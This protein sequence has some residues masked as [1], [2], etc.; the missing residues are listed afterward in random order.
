MSNVKLMIN[1]IEVEVPQ[2]TTLIQAAK[3]AGYNVP[4]LC[5]HPDLKPT[6]ACGVCIVDIEGSPVPK[7][8]CSTV[9]WEGMKVTTNTKKLREARKTLIELILANHDVKCPTCVANGKCELQEIA[10]TLDI[11]PEAVPSMLKKVPVDHSSVSIIRDVNKCINCGRCVQVCSEI[12][13]VNA[14]TFSNR[15]FETK[16]DTALSLGMANSVCVNC[17]QC[18]V[19]CPTGALHEKDDTAK[20]W[21]A[22]LDPTKH[23][24]VQEAPSIR[25]SLGEEFGMEFGEVNIGKMYAALKRLGFDGVFDTNYTADLTIIEEGSEV[26]SRVVN[27]GPLPC[28]TSCSPGWV[29]F[30]ETFFPDLAHHVSTAKSPQQMMG[31]L[32]KT[33][34]AEQKN[35]DAKDIVSVSIMPCTAKKFECQRDEMSDSKFQDVDYVL[36][37]RELIRMIH[38]AGMDFKNL[39]EEEPYY[40]LSHHTGAGTIFGATGGV[41]EAALR[42]VYWLVNKEDLGDIEITPVRGLKGIKEAEVALNADLTVKVA[43]AHGLGN[44]RKLME[45]VQKQIKET[46]KSEYTFIEIMACPGGCVGGGGQPFGNSMA[47]RARRGERL[48]ED[49][50]NLPARC[51]H[52]NEAVMGLYGEGNFLPEGPG[53]H[54]A[55]HLLHTHYYSREKF[56]GQIVEQV[57]GKDHH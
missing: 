17:G 38:E 32:A 28:I 20:V 42:S 26:V 45:K 48:Y 4:T 21:D 41:M 22:L 30:M 33:Y 16:I 53:G 23:V 7:R 49:D 29:K 25:A 50:R 43:V 55:H 46:G 13:T 54:T 34:Y 40:E 27:G 44:A 11:D 10:Y 24:V 52:H 57:T 19:Y 31:T 5:Y 56:K 8:A 37:T 18:T 14:L 47:D 35:I 9:V 15:G 51:S 36:T 39:P 1:N 3:K 12:Q 2:G 6:S